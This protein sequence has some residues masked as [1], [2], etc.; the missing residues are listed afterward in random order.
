MVVR[1][2]CMVRE[3]LSSKKLSR[4]KARIQRLRLGACFSGGRKDRKRHGLSDAVDLARSTCKISGA[5]FRTPFCPDHTGDHRDRYPKH[6][7]AN[8][9]MQQGGGERQTEKGLQ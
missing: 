4:P 2:S 9:L 3:Q 6:A 7:R 8:G 1:I 5:L